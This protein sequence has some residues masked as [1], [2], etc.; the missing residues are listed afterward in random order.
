MRGDLQVCYLRLLNFLQSGRR[1]LPARLQNDLFGARMFDFFRDPPP[2]Q[3]IRNFPEE[4]AVAQGYLL[5]LVERLDDFRIVPEPE[6]AQKDRS[7]ELALAVDANVKHVLGVVL[8]LH[9][10]SAIRNDLAQEIGLRGI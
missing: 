8:K 7:Q 10:G 2:H 6:G 3:A 9:P 4:L 5:D 1:D